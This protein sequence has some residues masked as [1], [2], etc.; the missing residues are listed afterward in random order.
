MAD[1]QDIQVIDRGVDEN[2]AKLTPERIERT[3]NRVLTEELS[4]IH[5]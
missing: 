1:L 5:I 4:L 3:I 2:I